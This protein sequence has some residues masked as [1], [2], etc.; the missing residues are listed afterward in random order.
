M[1]RNL[2]V[3]FLIIMG[4]IIM[5]QPKTQTGKGFPVTPSSSFLRSASELEA[6]ALEAMRGSGEAAINLVKYYH[7]GIFEE[8]KALP[9]ALIGAENGHV[10]S[11]YN[12]AFF[13]LNNNQNDLRGI[14][15]LYIA[16]NK[17]NP[18]AKERL[19]HLGL[20][21]ELSIPDNS[22]FPDTYENISSG[23]I[24]QCEEGA[25]QGNGQ[26]ALIAA[27]YYRKIA[28]DAVSAEYWYRIGAQNGNQECQYH[29]GLI[30]KEK[31]DIL[32]Q[33]R[34]EFWLLR[35][36]RN[37]MSGFSAGGPTLPQASAEYR[38]G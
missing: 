7:F 21:L 18:L 5:G 13:L 20:P 29:L 8:E 23:L 31:Q 9:W 1:Q 33:A 4:G 14:Y 25:S 35:S 32:D 27:E 6:L 26:A 22:S 16:A 37:G 38:T 2:L 36:K 3:F 19:I 34:G 11:A 30:L 17:G 15:W 24:K 10:I 12:T 28:K